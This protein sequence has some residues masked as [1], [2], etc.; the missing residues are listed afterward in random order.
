[1]KNKKKVDLKGQNQF[2]TP[3]AQIAQSVERDGNCI[4]NPLWFLIKTE[5]AQIAQSVEL[6][7]KCIENPLWFLIKTEM[8]R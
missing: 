6:S 7:G 5:I 2:N 8:P 1:M 3:H 4:E